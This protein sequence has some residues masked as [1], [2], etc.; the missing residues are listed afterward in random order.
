MSLIPGLVRAE[1][2]KL[3]TTRLWWIMLI[4]TLLLVGMYLGFFMAFAGVSQ[5]GGAM[6]ELDT[7]QWTEIAWAT[8]ASTGIFVMILGVVM[9]TSEYRYQ[10]I[11]GTFLVTP[12]RGLVIVAKLLAG[13]IVGALFALAVLV[14]EA[15]TVIPA[16]TL[17]GGEFSPSASRVPQISLGIVATLTLYAV[18]GIGLGALVRNQIGGIVAAVVWS[19]V[20]EGIFTGIPA[21]HGVGKWLPAGAAQALMSIDLDTGLGRPEWLPA[22]AGA[23]VLVGYGLVFAAVAAATTVRRDIT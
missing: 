12:R 9:M 18:F 8:G 13:L 7:P 4:V 21:L 23:L 15:V 5:D 22:W 20:I 10:T 3:F 14:F 19:Y 11:T 2:R 17:A 16:V 6:P 1:L